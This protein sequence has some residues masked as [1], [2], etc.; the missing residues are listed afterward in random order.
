MDRMPLGLDELVDHWTVLDDER[1]LI[2]GKRGPTRL[3]FTLLL[4]FYTQH[5]RFP[6]GRS[7]L[8]DEAVEFVARQVKVPASDLGFYEWSGSTLKNHRS[9][10]REHLGFRECSVAD[11]DKLTDWLAAHVANAERNQDRVREELLRPCRAERIE[12]PA[13]PRIIRIVRWALHSAQETWF[14]VIAARLSAETVSRIIALIDGGAEADEDQ[15]GD[16]DSVLALVKSVPGNVSLESMLTEIRKLTAI[17]AIGLPPGLFADVAPKVV[18]GWRARAAVESPSHLRRRLKNSP[19]SMVTLL[20]ALL[21]EREREVTDSLVDLL[22]ATV[23][24]IGARAERKVTEELINAF[25][26]VT[27]KENILFAIAE[28]SPARP[29]DAVREVVYPA[30]RGGESTLRELMHEYKTSGPAYRRTVQTTLRA[31]YTGHYRK[32]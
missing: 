9:Q 28:A 16:Q 11:A 10:V 26:R 27:G 24:R 13:P 30:V 17:R 6:S 19:Q 12:P 29:S 14:A 7:G 25:R 20:A 23:H 2:A 5:G 8:P 15:D 32:A 1:N 4:K 3:G 21:T 18:S 22:I 31:S